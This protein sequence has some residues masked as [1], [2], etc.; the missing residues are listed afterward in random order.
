MAGPAG[1]LRLDH[2][3]IA[4]RSIAEARRFW[5]ALGLHLD[6]EEEVAG[7]A[8]RVGFLPLGETLL[9]LL[10][11]TSPDSP[12][13][14][15][16]ERRG[17]GLHHLCVSV[18]DVRAAMAELAAAGFELLS[19][20]PQP[21]PTAAWCASSTH[22]RPA[23]SWSSSRSRPAAGLELAVQ[24]LPLVICATR[25]ARL[26][27]VDAAA[28]RSPAR[29]GAASNA[30]ALGSSHGSDRCRRAGHRPLQGT[31]G[32][33]VGRPAAARRH[34]LTV[35]GLDLASVDDWLR[36]ERAGDEALIGPSTIFIPTHRIVRVDLEETGA[37]VESFAERFAEA[38]GRDAREA[39]M[40]SRG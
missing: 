5:E 37:A 20:E 34:R 21:G 39:L 40:G 22:A 10:E 32:E 18:P 38:C 26:P 2:I 33:D 1:P 16:L 3:G 36:Q 6:G 35:R 28:V 14:R 15:H 31:E 27:V 13:A 29:G 4:V 17:P 25:S 30:D 7:E 12:I 23:V 24:P 9:E 19:P 8:V 11:P